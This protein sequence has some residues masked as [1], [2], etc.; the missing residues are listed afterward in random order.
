MKT[1]RKFWYLLALLII[2]LCFWYL[3]IRNRLISLSDAVNSSWDPLSVQLD[4]RYAIMGDLSDPSIAPFLTLIDASYQKFKTA[5]NVSDKIKA[6]IELEAQIRVLSDYISKSPDLAR[7]LNEDYVR[8]QL[9]AKRYNDNAEIYN[10]TSLK[11][12]YSAVIRLKKFS[13]S[14]PVVVIYR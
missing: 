13:Q 1:S 7:R 3:S 4:H 5:Q 14:Y 6:S 12:P 9:D 8:M 2:A 10:L 11:F